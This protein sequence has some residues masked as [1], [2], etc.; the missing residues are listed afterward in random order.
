[1]SD[2]TLSYDRERLQQYQ[3]FVRLSPGAD[4]AASYAIETGDDEA[5]MYGYIAESDAE[6]TVAYCY[7]ARFVDPHT[8]P[9]YAASSVDGLRP[10]YVFVDR[11]DGS[12]ESVVFDAYHRYAAT[13][14]AGRER[15]IVDVDDTHYHLEFAGDDARGGQWLTLDSWLEAREWMADAGLYETFDRDT[16]EYPWVMLEREHWWASRT[17]ALKHRLVGRLPFGGGSA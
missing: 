5:A 13:V 7:L 9:E 12:L 2:A 10:L 8:D 4:A 11:E 6:P 16:L 15:V 14:T 1:M 3:P 17:D